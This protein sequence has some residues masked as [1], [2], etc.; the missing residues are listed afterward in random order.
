MSNGQQFGLPKE[1]EIPALLA[2]NRLLTS[3]IPIPF[4]TSENPFK[5]DN[6]SDLC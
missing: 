1:N 2:K 5:Y 4:L 6:L 3:L